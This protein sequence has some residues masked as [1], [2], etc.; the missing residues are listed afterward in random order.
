[1]NI[2]GVVYS[3]KNNNNNTMIK[4]SPALGMVFGSG[5]GNIVGLL[6]KNNLALT[7]GMGAGLGLVIGSIV[8]A[9]A[10]YKNK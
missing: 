4:L 3:M 1:M 10:I 8:Y 5:F 7:A 6:T 2:K 9:I